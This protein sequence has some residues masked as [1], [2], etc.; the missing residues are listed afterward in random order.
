MVRK[1][2]A[3]DLPAARELSDAANWNQTTADWARVL[4]LEP[5]GCFAVEEDGRIVA[6]AT[7]VCY[8][9]SLA[10]VGMVL[11]HPESRRKGH[12]RRVMEAA[13]SWLDDRGVKASRLD[14]TDMGLPL[15][16]QLGYVV[17]CGAE[18]W[19]AELPASQPAAPTG[20]PDY[21]LDLRATGTDRSRLLAALAPE[22]CFGSARGYV[23]RRP[24]RLARYIGPCI[25]EDPAEAASLLCLALAGDAGHVFWDLLPGNEPAAAL[26]KSLGFAPVRHLKRMVRGQAPPEQHNLI[27]ALSGFET[28]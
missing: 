23:M 19:R 14:A 10:W 9:S 27:Y 15:Y 18:R 26:A 21:A 13:L 16:E 17:E 1:L 3:A 20:E 28:G 11:T 12:A 2:T 7:A 6:T 22:G 5:E 4:Q 24:G 25:A 8:G